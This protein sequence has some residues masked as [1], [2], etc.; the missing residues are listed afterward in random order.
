[1][2]DCNKSLAIY[3]KVED[4]V[5]KYYGVQFDEQGSAQSFFE[6]FQSLFSEKNLQYEYLKRDEF[7]QTFTITKKVTINT[8]N[9]GI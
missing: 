4:Q 1:M 2:S 8:R 7:D 3:L 6:A 9:S 5:Y